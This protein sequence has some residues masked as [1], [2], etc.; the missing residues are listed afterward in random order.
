MPI[1]TKSLLCC[2]G[3]NSVT[4]TFCFPVVL[5]HKTLGQTLAERVPILFV[6]SL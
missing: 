2:L 1:L 5:P 6:C 4:Q 3:F